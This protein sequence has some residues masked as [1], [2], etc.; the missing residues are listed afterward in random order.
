MRGVHSHGITHLKDICDRIECGTINV[1]AEIDMK[2]T[3]ASTLVVDADHALGMVSAMRTMEKCVEM[4]QN[5]G[6]AFATIHNANTYGYGAFYSMY[7]AMHKMIG[8][9]ACNTKAYVAPIGGSVPKLGTNPI[10]IA[11]PSGKHPDFVLDMATSQVAVNKIALAL[12]NGQSIPDSWAVGPDGEKQRI[13]QRPIRE[14][15]FPLVDIK[16]MVFSWPFH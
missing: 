16:G 13:R 10:T 4:A 11:I 2:Q 6:I 7:A 1:A 5:S 12:K 15:F 8:F 9:S 14:H 3:A